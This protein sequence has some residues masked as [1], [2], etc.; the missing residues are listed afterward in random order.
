MKISVLFSFFQEAWKTT[1][2]Q[3]IPWIFGAFLALSSVLGEKILTPFLSLQNPSFE[4]I[5]KIFLEK[6]D[7]ELILTGCLLLLIF[8]FY[9]FG[10]GNIIHSLS[11]LTKKMPE[12]KHFPPLQTLWKNCW[13]TFLIELIFFCFLFLVI[14]LLSLPSLFAF[15]FHSSSLPLLQ[16]VAQFFFIFIFFFLT[17][18]KRISFLYSFLSPLSL[19]NS[20][21]TTTLFLSRFFTPSLLFFFSIWIYSLFFTFFLDIAILI[22]TTVLQYISVLFIEYSI[23]FFVSFIFLSF[24]FVFE[25]TLWILF[26]KK[27]AGSHLEKKVLDSEKEKPLQEKEISPDPTIV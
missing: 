13:K 9:I 27:F 21:E 22:T 23:H 14:L 10:T 25:N 2:S 6:T 4:D 16:N 19:R 20:F 7:K 5:Q 11:F 26:F 12:E 18:F 3:R 8:L 24:F 15:F 1:F 17:L